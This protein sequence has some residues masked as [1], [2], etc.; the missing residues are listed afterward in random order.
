VRSELG[1]RW[2]GYVGAGASRLL[3]PAAASPLSKRLW[4]W[5]LNGGIAWR[6]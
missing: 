1:E 6:F 2:V 3:G 5:G 4:G